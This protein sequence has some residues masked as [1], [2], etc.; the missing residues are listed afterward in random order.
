MVASGSNSLPSHIIIRFNRDFSSHSLT[1][2]TYTY[3]P[4]DEVIVKSKIDVYGTMLDEEGDFLST[5][6]IRTK[7]EKE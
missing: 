3:F 7:H 6:H 4:L 5:V 1:R 2:H